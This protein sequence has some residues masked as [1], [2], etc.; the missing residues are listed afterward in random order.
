MQSKVATHFDLIVNGGGGA[1][2]W[3]T[4]AAAQRG[5]QVLLLEREPVLASLQST[6]HHCWL[7]RGFRHALDP[8]IAAALRWS[9]EQVL[10]E[11][12][13]CI[14]E[15]AVYYLATDAETAD[16]YASAWQRLDL[17]FAE[18]DPRRIG[19]PLLRNARVQRAFV[20]QDRMFSPHDLLTK[21]VRQAVE[22]GNVTAKTN[23]EV[24]SLI[25]D[26]RG[27]VTGVRVRDRLSG[28]CWIAEAPLTINATGAETDR[29]LK[30]VGV[31]LSNSHFRRFKA[32]LIVTNRLSE[33]MFV[34]L[35]DQCQVVVP[36]AD[37]NVSVVDAAS[38]HPTDD[39]KDLNPE[40]N[41][42]ESILSAV[43]RLLPS[44]NFTSVKPYC[45]IKAEANGTAQ[46]WGSRGKWPGITVLQHLPGLLSVWPGKF[47]ALPLLTLE[48]MKW[49]R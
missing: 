16:R 2:I 38:D 28:T 20:S 39:V 8:T 7:H 3:I 6:H 34:C 31:S 48:V 26:S 46:N 29:L 27:S 43:K 32:H 5:Q 18:L 24:T 25:M 49:L 45:C 42:V 44:A 22:T 11:A 40:P 15:T 17:S 4:R 9:S 33:S 13:D 21:F 47:S 30:T 14:E 37:S 23:S 41:V 19:E 12:A 1:G 10:A 36:H 35:D